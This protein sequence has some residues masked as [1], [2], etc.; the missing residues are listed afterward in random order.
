MSLAQ[1]T[2]RYRARARRARCRRARSWCGSR[3]ALPFFRVDR[4]IRAVS[5]LFWSWQ[6]PLMDALVFATSPVR[7]ELDHPERE[8]DHED[9][10]GRTSIDH[11][12]WPLASTTTRAKITIKMHDDYYKRKAKER[13]LNDRGQDRKGLDRDAG[14]QG[15]DRRP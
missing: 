3:A 10:R 14:Q 4:P 9:D 11:W 12:K 5:S 1:R 6:S 7:A 2:G 13:K 15:T 8:R